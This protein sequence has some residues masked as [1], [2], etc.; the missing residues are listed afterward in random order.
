M[1]DN[2]E[3]NNYSNQELTGDAKRTSWTDGNSEMIRILTVAL[4]SFL[5]TFLAIALLGKTMFQ[6]YKNM[7]LP[8]G[9]PPVSQ[10]AMNYS[11]TFDENEMFKQLNRD[12]EMMTPKFIT[13][14]V[15]PKFHVVK[16]EEN[17]DSYKITIDLKQFHDDEK[18]VIVDVKPHAVKISGKA[19]MKSDNAQSSFSYF[20]EMPLSKKVEVDDVKKEKIGNNYIITIP[21]ED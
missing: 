2:Y 20:Q 21:F 12:F 17:N 6:D 15:T 3:N 7:S 4:S 1:T 9:R 14:I 13:P 19:V 11:D 16:L 5:G 8:E 18:N 10:N